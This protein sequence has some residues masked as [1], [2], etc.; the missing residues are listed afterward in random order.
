MHQRRQ[1]TRVFRIAAYS[2]LALNSA[3][4]SSFPAM[5]PSETRPFTGAAA[6]TTAVHRAM[7]PRKSRS[8]PFP[9]HWRT[10]ERQG[11]DLLIPYEG[12]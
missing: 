12:T 1:K 6:T 11:T 7:T 2:A 8:A 5:N 10:W 3:M 9:G 4:A